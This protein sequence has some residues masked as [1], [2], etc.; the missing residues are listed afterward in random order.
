MKCD[1]QRKP[2]AALHRRG[3]ISFSFLCWLCAA[4]LIAAWLLATTTVVADEPQMSFTDVSG[5]SGID[6][7]HHDSS[8]GQRFIYEYVSAGMAAFDYDGDGLEDLYFLS[9]IPESKDRPSNRLYRNIGG[10]RFVDVTDTAG[11]SDTSHSL[12]VSVGD[13]DNDGDPDLFVNNFGPNSLYD[14]LGDGTFQLVTS[15]SITKD[16]K[17]GAAACFLDIENDGDLDIF[18]ANYVKFDEA[19]HPKR[20]FRGRSVYPSPQDFAPEPD[21]ILENLGDGRFIDISAKSG[22]AQ[23]AGTG[24]GAV[25]CD[26]DADGDI[27]IFVCN[28]VMEN[29][30][31]QNNGKGVFEE[32]GLLSGVALDFAGTR[33]GSMGVDVGDLDK[34]GLPDLV[35]TS[36]QD[37]TPVVYQNIGGGFFDDVTPAK[38]GLSEAAPLVTW[39]VACDDLDGD[40]DLDLFLATG[41]L[42][43]NVNNTDDSQSYASQNILYQNITGKFAKASLGAR[44]GAISKP[45][46]SRGCVV[47]DLD[48]DGDGDIVILNSRSTPT[49]LRNNAENN[50]WLA[51]RLVG[52]AC[53]RSAIGSTV[54]FATNAGQSS[55]HRVSG[56]GYQSD[57]GAVLR[58]AT[59]SNATAKVA[60]RFPGGSNQVVDCLGG[61]TVTI[62]QE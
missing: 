58:F 51:I 20:V 1:C 30:L 22:I 48:Q 56:R 61:G 44:P 7:V 60:V 49:L 54:T 16:A 62:I 9:G 40:S 25:A 15:S 41:H 45:R 18:V 32:A 57:F 59:K 55:S 26:F 52:T 2:T 23:S 34:D 53:N 14:N 33:Q 37:E 31:Y 50:V 46:V 39:G 19:S 13:F 42:I 43:D 24:M 12:G 38:G 3:L 11:L 28:D 5:Q 36:Y 4:L 35:V 10:L 8:G 47:S 27:D 6:F 21:Q 17:L 29:F